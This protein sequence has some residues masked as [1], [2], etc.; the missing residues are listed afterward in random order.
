MRPLVVAN[1]N[2]ILSQV[3]IIRYHGPKNSREITLF[4]TEVDRSWMEPGEKIDAM[5]TG[6]K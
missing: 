4:A 3:L 6:D 5:D 2:L 1:I